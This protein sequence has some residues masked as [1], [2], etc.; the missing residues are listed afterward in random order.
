MTGALVNNEHAGTRS[1]DDNPLGKPMQKLFGA[2]DLHAAM[3]NFDAGVK[4]QGL[5][6]I[7]A[8]IRW[9]AHHSALR[10]DDG[11]I[12]GASKL[13]QVIETVEMIRKGPLPGEVLRLAEELWDAVKGTRGQII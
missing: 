6:S 12:L 5:T 1:G 2:E 11:I 8:A 9:M 10:N 3:R 13:E 7:E 4:A